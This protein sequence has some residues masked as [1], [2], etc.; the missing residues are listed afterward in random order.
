M[1]VIESDI[2]EEGE[3]KPEGA[4]GHLSQVGPRSAEGVPIE[5]DKNE[6]NA[7]PKKQ[8]DPFQGIPRPGQKEKLIDP[9]EIF[10][11]AKKVEDKED[12]KKAPKEKEDE[13]GFI[14]E[15]LW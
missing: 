9:D 15:D 11:K 10:Q 4:P 14:E 6:Q 3:E 7:K 2:V 12:D 13:G 8:K 5:Q 1:E